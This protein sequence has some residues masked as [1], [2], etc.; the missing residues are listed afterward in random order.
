[1]LVATNPTGS[2]SIGHGARGSDEAV[3]P[4]PQ[5]AS[6]TALRISIASIAPSA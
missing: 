3:G 4:D 6:T 2:L 1:M 5:A